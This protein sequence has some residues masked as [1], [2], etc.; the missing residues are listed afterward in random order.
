[1]RLIRVED[2]CE[3]FIEIHGDPVYDTYDDEDF[4]LA[5]SNNWETQTLTLAFIKQSPIQ[6]FLKDQ[7]FAWIDIIVES[8]RFQQFFMACLVQVNV[9]GICQKCLLVWQGYYHWML[10]KKKKQTN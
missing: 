2:L 5:G 1:M 7:A 4:G 3:E 6:G 9:G 8:V 10:R